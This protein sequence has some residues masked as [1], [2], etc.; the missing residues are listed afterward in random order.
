MQ[1]SI[2]KVETQPELSQVVRTGVLLVKKL[3]L[4]FR[5]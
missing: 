4:K 5:T 2:P 3:S 1:V